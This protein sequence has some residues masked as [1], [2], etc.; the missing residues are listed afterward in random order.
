MAT[1]TQKLVSKEVV[2]DFG[3]KEVVKEWEDTFEIGL[4]IAG[5]AGGGLVFL[6]FGLLLVNRRRNRSARPEDETRGD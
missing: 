4:D 6:G 5:P 1:L 3:D 2:D